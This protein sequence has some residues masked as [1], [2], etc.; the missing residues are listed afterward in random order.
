MLRVRWPAGRASLAIPAVPRHTLENLAAAL[1]ACYAA[2][3]SVERCLPGFLDSGPGKGRGEP[4]ELPGLYLID[5]TYN[6]NPAAV[7]VALDEL[8]RV[9]KRRGGRPVAVL[10]DMRELG[11][12]E[13]VYH[14]RIGEYAAAAGVEVLWGVGRLSES[15][16]QGFR[17]AGPGTAPANEED[18]R[19]RA[20][21]VASPGETT[22]VVASLRR[23]DVVLLKA[24]RGLRLEMM[25]EHL[26]EVA[27]GGRWTSPGRE[28]AT[29]RSA[30]TSGHRE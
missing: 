12:D 17:D 20:G 11:P 5:D 23:G 19:T 26:V 9:A 14:R 7:Q 2:G 27:R 8:V 6:A 18:I 30:E 16:V 15:T 4:I 1:A 28:A 13:H 24:S 22:P 3:F 21:H 25:V 29:G 10:G